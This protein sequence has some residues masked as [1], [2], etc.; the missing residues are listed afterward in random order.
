MDQSENMK[1][2]GT[3]WGDGESSKSL[4]ATMPYSVLFYVPTDD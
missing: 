1:I 4:E 3:H 2:A